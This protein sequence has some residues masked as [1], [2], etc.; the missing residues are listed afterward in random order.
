MA[1]YKRALGGGAGNKGQAL[2]DMMLGGGL[3]SGKDT[4][5]RREKKKS[6]REEEKKSYEM[7]IDTS[8]K[9]REVV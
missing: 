3:M 1:D 8:T 9:A 4:K 5:K 2:M 6:R 7:I